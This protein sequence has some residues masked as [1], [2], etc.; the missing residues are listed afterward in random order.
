MDNPA[1]QRARLA[2]VDDELLS[3]KA[4]RVLEVLRTHGASFFADLQHDAGLLG[5]EVEQG[6]AEG[7][8]RVPQ[9]PRSR[10]EA[11]DE[12]FHLHDPLQVDVAVV[13]DP[14]AEE[15]VAMDQGDERDQGRRRQDRGRAR[16]V[17]AA[18]G[19]TRRRSARALY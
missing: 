8:V 14:S 17:A 1:A 9:R 6:L 19:R 11:P 4:R 16:Q 7:D 10:V 2:A 12:R 15:H 3:A 18:R 13:V 5:T